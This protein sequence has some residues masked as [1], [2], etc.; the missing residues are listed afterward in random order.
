MGSVQHVFPIRKEEINFLQAM[1]LPGNAVLCL[2][3]KAVIELDLF[4]IMAKAGPNAQISASEI[5]TSLPT[6]N[7]EAPLML[8]RMLSFLASYSIFKC[9]V[10]TDKDGVDKKLYSLTP[11]CS[12]YIR[13]EDGFAIGPLL[14]L[15]FEK[16][17]MQAWYQLKDSVLEGG[18][19]FNREYGMH[20]FDYP[21]TDSR[22]NDVLNKGLQ[23][24]TGV[25]MKIILEVYKG[26]DG[27]EE[28]IDVGGG[29][30]ASLAWIVSKYPKIRGINYDLPHVIKD[31]PVLQGV[32][33]VEG[34]MFE[35]VP[36]GK[37]IFMKLILHDWDDDHCIRLLKNCFEALPNCG[38]V[39]L[40]ESILPESPESDCVSNI[41]YYYD[42][43]M[44]A[45]CH[46]GKERT[47]KQL[48]ALAKAA[49]FSAI[50]PITQAYFYWVTEIYKT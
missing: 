48:E 6:S 13:N 16:V 8:D 10:V 22:V 45:Y 36:R 18:T 42:M 3:L 4:E 12:N 25:T 32:E 50:K 43:M 40:V 34:N 38:K 14:L 20:A 47:L 11:I 21:S 44:M 26:F 7:P 27:M 9:T 5:V 33:H 29:Y 39:I 1:Q 46:G 37:T 28:L 35:S 24:L 15:Q 49:G 23:N 31:A 17:F 2:V 30:G 41:S 19:P